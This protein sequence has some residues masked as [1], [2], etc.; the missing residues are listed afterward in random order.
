MP[1]KPK[2]PCSHP[3]CPKLS[4]GRFCEEHEKQEAKR[5]EKYQRDPATKKRYGRSWKRI[6]DRYVALHPLCEQCEKNG[7][8]TPT[9]E[10]HHIKPL[11]QGGTHD[12]HNLMSLCTSCHS[13]ITAREGGRWSRK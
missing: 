3:G 5:Y 11:S 9:E 8:M 4:H 2:T 1:Y 6:R 7:K 10:V 13:E 12:F